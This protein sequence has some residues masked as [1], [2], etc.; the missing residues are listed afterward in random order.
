[1]LILNGRIVS[2]PELSQ[3]IKP[4]DKIAITPAFYGG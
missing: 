4:G 3:E 1:M 2:S